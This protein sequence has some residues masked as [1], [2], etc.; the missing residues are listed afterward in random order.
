MK[1]FDTH[2]HLNFSDYEKDRE[3]IIKKTLKE[4]VF[5]INI[6]TNIK[7]S[8]K[9]VKI[10]ENYKE[11]VYAAIG[12]HPLH[13]DDE[14]FCYEDYK[15]LAEEKKVVAIGETGLD[16]K[17][18]KENKEAKEKQK[19]IFIE[20]I[21]LSKELNLPL[22]LHCRMAH[23]DLLKILKEELGVFG[24]L[25]CFSGNEKEAKEYMDLGLFLG[26]NG[27]IFKMNLKKEIKMISLSRMVLETDCPF[28]SP[29]L[30]VKRNE[31]LFLKYIAREVAKIKN[32]NEE[33]VREATTKNAK[34]LFNI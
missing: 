28:L 21:K 26:I 25:H 11:G 30:D 2:A 3:D 31:P 14:E 32:I 27:I 18:I 24:V 19:R 16:Y 6:G 17:Y 23:K 34:K 8:E 29:L 22:V 9:V 10:T 15:K 13:V 5:V 7:E 4:G 20:H 33:E 1:Y 12:L